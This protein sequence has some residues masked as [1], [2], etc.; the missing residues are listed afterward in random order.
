[1]ISDLQQ[2]NQALDPRQSFI[3]QAPAGSGK[4]GLLVYRYLR[5]LAQVENPQEVLAITFTRK[6]TAEML[7]RIIELLIEA[8]QGVESSDPFRQQGIYLA[9]KALANANNRNWDI[10]KAPEQLQ[11]LTIDSFCAKLASAMPWL[12]RLGDRPRVADD[13][14]THYSIAVERVFQGLLREP[15]EAELAKNLQTVLLQ[16][17]FNYV[18]ARDLFVSMLAKR[19]QWLRHLSSGDL[20]A[21]REALSQA[22]SQL[23]EEQ[24]DIIKSL[25]EPSLCEEL[26]ELSAFASLN[27]GRAQ[28]TD[29]LSQWQA[30]A[31]LLLTQ[32]GDAFR[33][34]VNVRNGFPAGADESKRIK[35]ILQELEN[36]HELL[37]RLA[38]L[39]LL[40]RPEFKDSDW[41]LLLALEF[42]LKRLA[43]ELQL[44]FRSTG[45]CDYSEVT[46]RAA[47]A[48]QEISGYSDL[49]MRLDS[50]ISHI[51]VDEF[52]D[53]SLG[54]L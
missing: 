2:R 43:A 23:V 7:D 33:K 13:A 19:D 42:V 31:T 41:Q 46:Q 21:M 20:E 22:W 28:A 18:R 10:L 14:S 27:V 36:N 32:K 53:T 34:S 17:D 51:L 15:A 12:S 47:L 48:L 39:K 44:R 1:M 6:A 38:R 25:V 30:L 50:E 45:E 35:T 26:L 37:S 29:S 16:L 9:S 40:P 24:L 8:E 3:V 4:T 11:I 49:S 5:L 52:Q 54:Q